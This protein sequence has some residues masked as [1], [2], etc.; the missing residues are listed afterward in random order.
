MKR[1]RGL[2][3]FE[4]GIG[5]GWLVFEGGTKDEWLEMR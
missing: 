3:A 4:A 5:M 2:K 1:A